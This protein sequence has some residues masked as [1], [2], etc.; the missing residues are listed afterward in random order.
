MNHILKLR[1]ETDHY[2]NDLSA[3]EKTKNERTRFQ[4]ENGDQE[5]QKRS[6]E[7]KSKRQKKINCL[8]LLAFFTPEIPEETC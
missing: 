7:K 4:K 8:I 3:K 6:E 2:E 5:R 1:K